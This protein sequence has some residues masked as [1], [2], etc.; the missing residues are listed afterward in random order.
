MGHRVFQRAVA[1]ASLCSLGCSWDWDRYTPGSVVDAGSDLGG[2]MDATDAPSGCASDTECARSSA[3]R[4]LCDVGTGRCVAC[5]PSRDT[6]GVGRYCA[7]DNT[8]ATGCGSDQGCASAPSDGGAIDAGVGVG[9]C[10]LTIHACVQCLA[11][12]HCPIGTRCVDRACVPGCDAA[13]GCPE[14]RACCG[15][16]CVDTAADATH[17][18]A[19]G[20]LCSTLNGV[21]AC[22]GGR[23]GVARCN[24]P[25]GDCDGDPTTGCET[26]TRT[27]VAHCGA[28]GTACAARAN[29]TASCAEG[30]C[31]Y[32]CATGFGDCD[33]DPANG[34]ETDLST[35]LSNCGRCGTACSFTGG[36]GACVGGVCTR[37]ACATGRGD[38]DGNT[39]NGCEI[40]LQS[41]ATNCRMCGVACSFPRATA[42]CAS[43]SCAIGRCETGSDN[44]DGMAANGCETDL[45][46]SLSHCGAC[47]RSCAFPNAAASCSAGVCSIGACASGMGNCD[48]SA[49]NGCEVN[50]TTSVQHCGRCGMACPAR[51]NAAA[52]CAAG[53]CGFTCLAGFADCDGVASNGCEVNTRTSS[54]HCGS[55]GAGCTLFNAVGV[56]RS[57]ACAVGSCLSGFADCDGVASNGCEVDT[58]TSVSDCGACGRVCAPDNAVGACVA[59]ACNIASCTPNFANCDFD[60]TN[61]CETIP[62]ANP[63]HCGACGIACVAG[64]MCEAGRCTVAS[65]AGYSVAASPGTVTWVDACVAPGAVQ[66]LVGQDDQLVRGALPF[67]VEFWGSTN[68]TYFVSS[69]GWVGFGDYYANIAA[70][71][72]VTPYRHFGSLPRDGTPYPAAY[73]FGVDLVQGSRG[74]CI[75]TLGTAPSRRFVVQSNAATLFLSTPDASTQLS[76]SSFSYEL[77]AYEGSSV[78]DMVYSAPFFGPDSAPMIAQTNVSV[79]LQD[80]HL[81]LRA[82]TWTGAVSGT[83]RIRFTPN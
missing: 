72:S 18:G 56:C 43:G 62:V 61:G 82:A 69:N 73:V 6:C 35:T 28:C 39:A 53:A 80:F 34:C 10:D 9:R 17:C 58:R 31:S 51:A 33:G 71:P 50:T 7:S 48:G 11:N 19:C 52:T 23:C 25:F 44:C 22:A 74:V 59:G 65:F 24:E 37:T 76:P 30:A 14:G 12:E 4:P 5:I 36:V 79:G 60:P 32:A 20:S 57:G 40:D 41:D 46:A 68:F 13:R 3:D 64:R 54:T 67:P 81:P 45:N 2:P 75:A 42:I 55:C 77:I 70:V 8:C 26:N 27:A 63:L 78:L 15:G 1:I 66:V 83:T 29:A 16:G 47:G 49:V 21:P 38:C